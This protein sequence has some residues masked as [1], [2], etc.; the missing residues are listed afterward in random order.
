MDLVKI[1]ENTPVGTPLYSTV[2]GTLYFEKIDC[3]TGYPIICRSRDNDI[4][5]FTKD[6]KY[7]E[8]DGECVLFP[9]KDNKNWNDFIKDTF[10]PFDKVLVRDSIYQPWN[11]TFFSYIDK[12]SNKGKYCTI[13]GYHWGNC[14]LYEGNEHLLGVVEMP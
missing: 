5:R 8:D 11:L 2:F 7:V 3:H 9:S 14:I 12:G 10:K 13:N 6:G 1:L 4:W